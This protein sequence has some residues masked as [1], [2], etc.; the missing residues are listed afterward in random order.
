M[1]DKDDQRA[2]ARRAVTE[3]LRRF[4]AE[5]AAQLAAGTA[6][7][8]AKVEARL[9]QKPAGGEPLRQPPSAESRQQP[10]QQHRQK[11]GET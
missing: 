9:A 5:L 10:L 7:I 1:A 11:Q 4:I 2:A 6:E 3:R 8:W